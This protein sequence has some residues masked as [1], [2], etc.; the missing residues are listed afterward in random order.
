MNPTQQLQLLTTEIN[1]RIKLKQKEIHDLKILLE[2]VLVILWRHLSF[3]LDSRS[4]STSK[5]LSP[6]ERNA[7]E[8]VV[9]NQ[10]L[11]FQTSPY[12]IEELKPRCK[13][14]LEPV[15]VRLE[16]ISL[17]SSIFVLY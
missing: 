7:D 17:V 4:I 1:N 2:N 5:T 14:E 11:L 15:L 13:Q 8:V 6:C 16:N 10:Q 9:L 12:L 3:Y